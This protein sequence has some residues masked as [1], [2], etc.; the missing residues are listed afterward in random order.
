MRVIVAGDHGERESSQT[1]TL[2]SLDTQIEAGYRHACEIIGRA[3]AP[4]ELP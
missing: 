3:G 2:D 1:L 4:R